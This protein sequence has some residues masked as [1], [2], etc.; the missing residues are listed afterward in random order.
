[1]AAKPNFSAEPNFYDGVLTRIVRIGI[2]LG[3][4]GTIYAAVKF[5][6]RIGIGFLAGA[7]LS[8][9]NFHG[10]RRLVE[11]LEALAAPNPDGSQKRV[12][13][14][15]RGSWMFWAL[16]YAIFF[17]AAYVIVKGLN[18]S[19]MPVLAGLFVVAAAILLEI[20][21]ELTYARK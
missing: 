20:V 10:L 3:A 11:G 5:G 9:L 13:A 8:I 17:G 21:Y 12:S 7:I 14:G 2:V 16:R 4:A 19:L 18:I 15:M 6:P 1:M